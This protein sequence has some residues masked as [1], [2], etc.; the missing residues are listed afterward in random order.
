MCLLK[1]YELEF[2]HITSLIFHCLGFHRCLHLATRKAG[3]GTAET[4]IH[5]SQIKI[6]WSVTER[7]KESLD[8]G[9]Q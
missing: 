5:V 2:A 3:K 4:S 1:E 8:T 6:T 9:G 7:K